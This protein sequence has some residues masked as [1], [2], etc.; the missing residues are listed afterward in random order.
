MDSS[1]ARKYEGT[2]LG[3][4]LTKQLV[5]LHGGE[6]SFTS[7]YDQGSIFTFTVPLAAPPA[8]TRPAM[9]VVR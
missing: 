1:F 9:S 5:E 2:G 3:L 8:I 7:T 4:A 6:M